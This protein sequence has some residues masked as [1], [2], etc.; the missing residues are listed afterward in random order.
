MSIG[1]PSATS[2]PSGLTALPSGTKRPA[3]G[4]LYGFDAS[5]GGGGG[6]AA[7]SNGFAVNFDGTNDYMD[8]GSTFESTFQSSFSFSLWVKLD[9]GG[10]GTQMLFATYGTNSTSRV[11]LF[12]SSLSPVYLFMSANGVGTAAINASATFTD[13][14]HIVGTFEQSGSNVIKTLY[15]NGSQSATLTK[16]GMTLAN[17]G[18][19]GTATNPY[20]GARNS[21]NAPSLYGNAKIDEL[22]IIP[23][24]L[25]SSD[26]TAIYNSGVPA[27]LTSYS[28][29]GWWRM[30]DNDGGTGTTITDQG[31]G[32]NNGTLVNGPTFSTDVPS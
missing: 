15:V 3:F 20:V 16:A 4:T 1:F 14:S 31:S 6:G 17:Y 24:V 26:V 19:G 25:S 21:N 8:T 30:G 18:A 10:S 12:A 7:F 32:G 2:K 27:D 23:S 13:W 28:P 29:V 9:S 5:G 22:A 11:V